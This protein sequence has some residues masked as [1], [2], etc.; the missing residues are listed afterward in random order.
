MDHRRLLHRIDLKA[1]TIE[2]DGVALPAAAT[3]R[4]PTIDPADPYDLS[5]EEQAC[6]DRLRQSFLAEP[7]ALASTCSSWSAGGDVPGT[8]RGA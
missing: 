6:V 7:E 3:R 1:G 8:R 2:I 5:A 4:F